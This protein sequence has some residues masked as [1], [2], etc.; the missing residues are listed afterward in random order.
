[1]NVADGAKLTVTNNAAV[2]LGY[3]GG[4]NV[5][6][7][8]VLPAGTILY[9]N[10]A[11]TAGDDIYCDENA[12]ITFGVVGT[13]WIL[14]DCNDKID[15]WYDDSEEERWKAHQKPVHCEEYTSKMAKPSASCWH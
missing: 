7:Q 9:N 13:D 8:L 14:D 11:A 12:Q 2:K 5:R 1:M 3:G 15:G 6:G 4:V 10:H